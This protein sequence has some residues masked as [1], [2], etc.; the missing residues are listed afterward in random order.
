MIKA[1]QKIVQLLLVA[2][3]IL[4]GSTQN[5]WASEMKSSN[6]EEETTIS[7]GHYSI[8]DDFESFVTPSAVGC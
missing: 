5:S 4:L 8:S 7:I 2:A 3:F 6:I 1:K